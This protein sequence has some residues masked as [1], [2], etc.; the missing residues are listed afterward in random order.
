MKIFRVLRAARHA[1][2][3]APMASWK[4]RG[5]ALWSYER[6]GAYGLNY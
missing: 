2:F 1:F 5:M 4:T 6:Y 3:F